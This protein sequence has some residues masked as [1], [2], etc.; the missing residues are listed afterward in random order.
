[1]TAGIE[2][3]DARGLESLSLRALGRAMGTSAT[4]VYRYFPDK[5][6]LYSAM[7]DSLLGAAVTGVDLE[8]DPR[9]VLI[10]LAQGFRDQARAHPCLGPLMI[11]ARLEGPTAYAV[12]MLVGAAMRRLG[13]PESRLALA[14]RQL[15]SFVV[16]STLFDFSG[17]PHHLADRRRR[18]TSAGD[19]GFDPD[20]DSDARVEAV[21]E[22]AFAATLE[23]L[24]DALG[25]HME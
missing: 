24:L 9:S 13:V 19:L 12:P 8:A 1:M 17:A 25:S 20:L 6:A 2:Y 14:Y 23:I 18:L 7:R 15:E 21:N 5:E 10:G 16:G 22:A 4:A 3:A 11:L